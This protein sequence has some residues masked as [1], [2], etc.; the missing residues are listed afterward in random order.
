MH[1]P[2]PPRVARLALAIYPKAVQERYGDEIADLLIQ[3]P[4]PLRDLID[5]AWCALIEQGNFVPMPQLRS[6][7]PRVA[8]V[9]AI[10]PVLGA[11][12]LTVASLGIMVVATIDAGASQALVETVTALAVV[13]VGVA[14]SWLGLRVG[15]QPSMAGWLLFIPALLAL[16]IL[17]L[18][19]V[20]ILG[21]A[22]GEDRTAVA[23]ATVVWC[24]LLTGLV[25]ATRQLAS[26]IP[27]PT[28][29]LALI[30]A[31]FALL[32][33]TFI[34][35]GGIESFPNA[36]ALHLWYPSAL[37]MQDFGSPGAATELT[38]HLKGLPALLTTCTA[39]TLA[40]AGTAGRHTRRHVKPLA[41]E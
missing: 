41:T 14:A 16:S 30:L 5:V 13:P 2:R 1:S 29:V 11:A 32:D 18:S 21:E 20:P 34:V 15:Q 24:L 22:L 40:L 31:G 7:A 26:R 17:A 23:V 6:R 39:F 19:S 33:L 8:G 36:T 27:H 28:A 3:S 9:L 35:Y 4:Q 37:T 38:E 12:L 10:P 25:V